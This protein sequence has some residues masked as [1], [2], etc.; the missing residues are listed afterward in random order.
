[1]PPPRIVVDGVEKWGKTTMGA[2]SPNPLILMARGESGYLTLLGSGLVPDVDR[3]SIETWPALLAL[4]DKLCAGENGHETIVLDAMGGFERLCHEYVCATQFKNDWGEHGFASYQRGY[5]L[6]V[7]DWLTLLARLDRLRELRGA[8]ILFLSH[9]KVKTFKNPLGPDYDR[10]V[11]DCHEKTW[12]V[13]HKWADAVLFA[14]YYSV[15]ETKTSNTPDSLRR[16]KGIGAAERVIYTQRR[17]AF[18]AGNRYGM[19]ETIDIPADPAQSWATL[20][21]AIEGNKENPR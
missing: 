6:A 13:T 10:W 7:T 5:D 19:A 16:G 8:T 18:D 3:V 14:T 1:M 17:D 11:S 21:A 15:V 4:L 2:F 12:G 9:C 20:W